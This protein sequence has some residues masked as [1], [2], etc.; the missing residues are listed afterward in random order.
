MSRCEEYQ[1]LI[2][3]MVDGELS[4]RRKAALEEHIRTCED[5]AALYSAFSALSQQIGEDLEDVP[6]DLRENVMAEI[7]REKIRRENRIPAAL[8][9]ILAAAA[10]L[11]VIVGVS[12][13]VSPQLR[14]RI[15]AAAYPKMAADSAEMI[16][17]EPARNF[18]DEE[19]L[20][21][22]E[23]AAEV[24]EAAITKEAPAEALP[25][26]AEALMTEEALLEDAL[27]E[28][29]MAEMP[30]G[31]AAAQTEAMGAP[32]AAGDSA[33]GVYD[34]SEWM[35]RTLLRQLLGGEP[36]SMTRE[37]L[38]EEAAWTL[39]IK[40]ETG[41]V[42]VPVCVRDGLLYYW[43]PAENAVCQARLTPEEFETFLNS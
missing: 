41:A 2:S 18:A 20:P 31:S 24:E 23:E 11:A 5:C 26:A 4:D 43:D 8:R 42:E 19:A 3:R 10:C 28:E 12:L 37:E 39:W 36:A 6:L 35:D 14:G 29:P 1:E 15:S 17:E 22:A 16:A 32:T 38:E 13:G 40:G 33:D 30:A 34:F 21:A 7:R 25:D 9:G 27:A